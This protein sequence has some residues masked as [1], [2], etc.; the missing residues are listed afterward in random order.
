MT[1]EDEEMTDAEADAFV[2]KLA[3][4]LRAG[5]ARDLLRGNDVGC[6][7]TEQYR[8]AYDRALPLPTIP[9]EL[10]WFYVTPADHLRSI[11]GV[12]REV[13]PGIW[14]DARAVE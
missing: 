14:A 11:P 2:G 3:T 1:T 12:V 9:E 8:A 5:V 6:F 7:T 13:A 10:R 4:S